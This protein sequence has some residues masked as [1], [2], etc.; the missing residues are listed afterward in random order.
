MNLTRRK[1]LKLLGL[2]SLLSLYPKTVMAVNKPAIDLLYLRRIIT[3]DSA[4]KQ[5]IMWQSPVELTDTIFEY[6]ADNRSSCQ[7]TINSEYLQQDNE[8]CYFYH[9]T[10]NNLIPA[11]TY[12]YRIKN[13]LIVSDWHYFTTAAEDRSFQALLFSDSQCGENY[14]TWE[15]TLRIACNRHQAAAFWA[16]IGDLTDNGESS[17]HWQSFWQ[18]LGNIPAKLPMVPVMGNHECYGL[19]WQYA[20]PARYLKS[21]AL[22]ING[23]H[24]HQGY[25]YAF[26]YGPVHFYILNTQML[27]LADFKPDL[28]H[29]QIA[30]L[31]KN[32]TTHQKKWQVVLMHKDVL[33]YDEY[34]AGTGTTFGFSDVGHAFMPIFDELGI[35]LVVTGH[36]HTYRNRGHIKN[37]QPSTAGPVYIMGGPA[38]NEE[39]TVPADKN[40][41]IKAISQPTPCNY[42]LL[43]ADQHNL[44]LTCFTTAGTLIDNITISK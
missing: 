28:L 43:S 26:D 16:D 7:A 5:T 10:I 6:V 36:M 12:K 15:K 11:R 38:G 13:N 32:K 24:S 4:H 29:D 20:L 42:L 3:S 37:F 39:Y 34:Q 30:W 14:T 25:Y 31:K 23:S 21:F 1:F 17:W 19:N 35:D 9:V 41:D 44:K 22:P 33:A 2:G 27:E 8:I 40:F 18:A